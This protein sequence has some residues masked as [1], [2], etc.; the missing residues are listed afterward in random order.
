MQNIRTRRRYYPE[1]IYEYPDGSR[2]VIHTGYYTQ[3]EYM[4]GTWKSRSCCGSL[5][6][7]LRR[8]W[9]CRGRE[10]DEQREA[11]RRRAV[12]VGGGAAAAAA[13][14]TAKAAHSFA[15]GIEPTNDLQ[16]PSPPCR[17]AAVDQPSPPTPPG[18][19]LAEPIARRPHARGGAEQLDVAPEGRLR[20]H[21]SAVARDAQGGGEQPKAFEDVAHRHAGAVHPRAE[22]RRARR[23]STLATPSAAA[24]IACGRRRPDED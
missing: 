20:A 2:R 6:R 15:A 16:P 14:A 10:L 24:R 4:P 9:R 1:N 8:R 18:C 19:D 11:R 17:D 23:L 21:E 5:W 22:R 13:V 12:T 7:L 3:D